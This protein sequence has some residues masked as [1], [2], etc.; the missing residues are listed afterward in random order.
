MRG[1]KA[2][3]IGWEDYKKRGGNGGSGIPKRLV[4]KLNKINNLIFNKKRA[5]LRDGKLT[6]GPGESRSKRHGYWGV[7]TSFFPNPFGLN[8]FKVTFHNTFTYTVDT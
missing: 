5:K 2:E 4:G 6:K 3:K 1:R 7:Q 8:M